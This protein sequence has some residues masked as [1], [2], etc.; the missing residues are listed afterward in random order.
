MSKDG[1]NNASNNGS[2]KVCFS[3]KDMDKTARALCKAMARHEGTNSGDIASQA[4]IEKANKFF[5]PCTIERILKIEGIDYDIN[6]SY[7]NMHI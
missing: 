7:W 2:E 4:I 3:T 1:F 5:L 6:D